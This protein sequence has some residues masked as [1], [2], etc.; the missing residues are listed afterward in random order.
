MVVLRMYDLDS[1]ASELETVCQ[2]GV[3]VIF[4]DEDVLFYGFFVGE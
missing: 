2:S 3:H 1:I 4:R